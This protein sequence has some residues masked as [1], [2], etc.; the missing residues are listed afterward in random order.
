MSLSFKCQIVQRTRAVPQTSNPIWNQTFEFDEIA[1]GEYLKLKCLYE[2]T[3]GDDVIGSATVNL[4][5]LEEGSVRDTPV[6]LEKTNSGE[7]RLQIKAVSEV[8]LFY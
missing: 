4:E 3:F 7:V 8:C 6:P 5:G 1:G 2:E